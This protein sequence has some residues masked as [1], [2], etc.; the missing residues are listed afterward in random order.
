MEE[1][2]ISG[3]NDR[4]IE[5]I[6]NSPEILRYQENHCHRNSLELYKGDI[7]DCLYDQ[8]GYTIINRS[9]VEGF[10]VIDDIVFPHIWNA[11][12]ISKDDVDSTEYIDISKALFFNDKIV[13]YFK[14]KSYDVDTL[15]RNNENR[16]V[17]SVETKEMA[18]KFASENYLNY[19]A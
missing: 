10:A 9:I 16:S 8:I 12:S 4:T 1:I 5:S 17:F 19:K 3:L 6:K 7:M 13:R 15:E 2:Y 14:T 18:Q 11:F